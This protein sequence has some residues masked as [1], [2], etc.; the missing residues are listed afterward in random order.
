MHGPEASCEV[1]KG[2]CPSDRERGTLIAMSKQ[3]LRRPDGE[4]PSSILMVPVRNAS[5][6]RRRAGDTDNRVGVLVGKIYL[7]CASRF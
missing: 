1:S 3:Q 7:H 4:P 2:G 6:K 5:G